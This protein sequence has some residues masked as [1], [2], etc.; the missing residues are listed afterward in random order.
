MALPIMN[1]TSFTIT[2]PSLTREVRFRP[3]LVKEEKI[4]L[5]AAKG[6]DADVLYAMRQILTNCCL[7]AI[8]IG[9]LATFDIVYLFLKLRARSVGAVLDLKYSDNEDGKTYD[10]KVDL[11]TIEVKRHPDHT[12]KFKLND[13]I[14][15]IMRY[16]DLAMAEAMKGGSA[17]EIFNEVLRYCLVAIW[18]SSEVHTVADSP[19]EEVDAFIDSLDTPAFEKIQEFF[20]TMPT[21]EHVLE[22]TNA[23]GKERVIR[24]ETVKDFFTWG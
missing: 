22:Y 14:G 23:N 21:V 17:L 2:I 24:L 19:M 4:L 15:V 5:L 13:D 20:D 6:E 9:A 8:D 3:W 18:D 16:P 12:T 11:N 1:H 10:F 7:E